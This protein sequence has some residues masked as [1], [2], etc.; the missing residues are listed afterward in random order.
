MRLVGDGSPG[1]AAPAQPGPAQIDRYRLLRGVGQGAMGVVFEAEHVHIGK[2]VAVKLLHRELAR[3]PMAVERL[4]REAHA[5][6]SIGHRNIV[7][8]EDFGIAADGAVYLVMEW[9]AGETLADRLER[10][11]ADPSGAIAVV[12]QVLA[13]LAA[14]HAAGVVHR[15][16]KPANIF[17]ARRKDGG[18]EVKLLDF[19]IA[20]LVLADSRLTRTGAFVGTPDYV[21][22]EQALGHQVDAR[23]DLYS[24]GVLM[25]RLLTDTLPFRGESFMAVLHQ[26]TMTEPE[27]PSQRAPERNIAPAIEAVVLR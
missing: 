23:A 1:P 10:G 20:K 24:V 26:H 13:A 21:A 19:G 27:P 17:L 7:H 16:L 18:E 5:A 14:A 3:D 2:R 12:R 4:R 9:L 25:Y 8:V 22:P 6:S 15:D 11:P